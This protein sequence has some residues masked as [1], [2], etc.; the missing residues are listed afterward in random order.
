MSLTV[1]EFKKLL[2]EKGLPI[3]DISVV[4]D[5][6]GNWEHPYRTIED[7]E[8]IDKVLSKSEDTE[9]PM[10]CHYFEDFDFYGDGRPL[11]AFVEK[12]SKWFK[13]DVPNMSIIV[14]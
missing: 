14:Y 4:F 9:L 2:I 3:K 10:C 8:T 11:Y 6:T 12:E 5:F 13:K 7:W 1:K